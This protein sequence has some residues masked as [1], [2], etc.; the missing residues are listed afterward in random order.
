M[1]PRPEALLA[2]EP[3]GLGEAEVDRVFADLWDAGEGWTEDATLHLTASLC[4]GLPGAP[5]MTARR[6]AEAAAWMEARLRAEPGCRLSRGALAAEGVTVGIGPA[7][8]DRAVA[9][10]VSRDRLAAAGEEPAL[11]AGACP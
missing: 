3:L 2:L 11:A 7:D 4:R 1:L 9:S 5:A 10:L 8:L 6:E